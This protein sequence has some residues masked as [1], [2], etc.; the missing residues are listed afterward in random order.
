VVAEHR[1]DR[2]QAH[3][4]VDGLGGQ[5]VSH[6]VRVD[7]WQAG[8]GGGFVEVAGDAVP[9]HRFAVL[10]R[11]QEGIVGVDVTFAVVADQVDQVWVQRQVT[12][13]V[14]FPDRDV[15]PVPGADLHDRVRTQTGQFADPQPGAQQHLADHP[16]QH[17]ALRLCRA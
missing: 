1:C 16:D 11:Q 6:L 8:G 5:G 15:Q 12:V 17:P 14:K 4:A 13:I 10:S 9:V 2:F 7:V 3:P